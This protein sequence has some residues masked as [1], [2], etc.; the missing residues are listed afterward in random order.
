MAESDPTLE[1]RQFEVTDAP[2]GDLPI[3]LEET[4]GPSSPDGTLSAS[5]VRLIL[6]TR[7]LAYD[8]RALRKRAGLEDPEQKLYRVLHP[9]LVVHQIGVICALKAR[10]VLALRYEADFGSELITT[11][12]LSPDLVTKTSQLGTMSLSS[13]I[14]TNGSL[15]AG[16]EESAGGRLL[17]LGGGLKLAM[18]STLTIQ[19]SLDLCKRTVPLVHSAGLGSARAEWYFRADDEP[20]AGSQTMAQALLAPKNEQALKFR[21]RGEVVLGSVIPGLVASKYTPWV[22]VTCALVKG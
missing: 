1:A 4:M 18:G 6:G 20:L 2:G 14:E 10:P 11:M 16:G 12:G 3:L 9:W 21:V 15:R 19:S 7:P 13:T 22:D 8:L 17:P 5:G